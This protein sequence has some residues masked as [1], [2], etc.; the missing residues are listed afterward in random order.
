M[1]F[2]LLGISIINAWVYEN[3]VHIR[4]LVRD[5]PANKQYMEKYASPPPSPSAVQVA[6]FLSEY[7]RQDS[8]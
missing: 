1:F 2:F 8:S 6:P 3:H 5:T 7:L 4:Y